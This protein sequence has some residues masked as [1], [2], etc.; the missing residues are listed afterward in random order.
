MKIYK[1]VK[2]TKALGV[3]AGIL[4]FV[5]LLFIFA[6]ECKDGAVEGI[7][8]CMGVLIP[9]LFPFMI[10]SSFMAENNISEILSPVFTPVSKLFTGLG[11][12]CFIPVM[13]SIAGGYPVGARAISA[14][15]SKGLIKDR[16]A[17]QL[18]LI[19]CGAG[20]GFLVTFVGVTMLES[21]DAGI[22][23]LVS[24][25]ISILSLC[26]IS[27]IGFSR[28]KE[29]TAP[30]P[31][32]G[33]S[34]S[35]SEAFVG[36]VYSAVKSCG[37][38]CGYVVL[39]SAVCNIIT[40]GLGLSGV[41]GQFAVSTLEITTGVYNLE[42]TNLTIVSGLVGFGGICV[43]LQI[44][45][46]LKGVSFSKSLFYVYR[47][48]S[49]GISMLCTRVLLMLFPIST[50]VFSSI[51]EKPQLTFYSGLAGCMGLVLTSV[52]FIFSIRNKNFT[53]RR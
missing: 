9:S 35:I 25:I 45:R 2:K 37:S 51:S 14:L 53:F 40:S 13:L 19:C 48:L 10:L 50:E 1:C 4:T 26:V 38:M 31:L 49:A 30:A 42:S 46:E 52:L 8:M 43:H 7:L 24:Q 17:A 44:F 6:K 21:K 41:L 36:A 34:V 3:W 18:A 33:A 28:K 27:R 22:I 20:P 39:M 23:L 32:P 12:I 29:E 11:G 47:L 5:A 16:E 15:K